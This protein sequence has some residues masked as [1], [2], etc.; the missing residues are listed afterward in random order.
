VTW[1]VFLIIYFVFITFNSF[2]LSSSLLNVFV[3]YLIGN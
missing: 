1:F 3:I 2:F